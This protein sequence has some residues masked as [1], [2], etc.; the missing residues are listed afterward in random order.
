MYSYCMSRHHYSS[1]GGL[2][3]NLSLINS[4]L[5]IYAASEYLPKYLVGEKGASY[6]VDE[7]PF[8]NAVGTYK[9]LWDWMTERM[10]ADQV[11]SNGPGYP[12][13]PDLSNC[14]VAPDEKG[15]FGRPELD[16]FALAMVGGG[17][18]SG[19]AHAFG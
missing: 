1:S 2:I 5:H 8:Q 16:N 13:V 18:T 7:T 12:S 3:V 10:P 17:K 4:G 15:L 6:K 19:A 11:G 9:P 14:N